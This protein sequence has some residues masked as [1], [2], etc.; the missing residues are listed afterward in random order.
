M[1]KADMVAGEEFGV[2]F[3][4]T[5]NGAPS[6]IAGF[7]A[8]IQL[9]DTSNEGKELASWNDSSPEITRDDANGIVSLNIPASVTNQ[10]KF[11][12]AY[13]DLLLL[14]T[15]EGRRSAELQITLHRGVT[16]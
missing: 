11:K 13:M 6:S 16:R 4:I 12:T 14:K 8:K 3:E 5:L 1:I 10:F 2:D 7:D 15:P 9:R